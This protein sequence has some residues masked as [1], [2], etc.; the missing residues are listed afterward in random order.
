[1]SPI[2]Y[3]MIFAMMDVEE[4]ASS[5]IVPSGRRIRVASTAHARREKRETRMKKRNRSII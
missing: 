4:F 3:D 5:P 2:A 1:M